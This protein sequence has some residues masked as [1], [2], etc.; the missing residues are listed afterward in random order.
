MPLL[1]HL[2]HALNIKL[3]ALLL[4]LLATMPSCTD[5]DE[6]LMEEMMPMIDSSS[7]V[8]FEPIGI[9]TLSLNSFIPVLPADIQV[10]FCRTIEQYYISSS[11]DPVTGEEQITNS[12][13]SYNA[14]NASGQMTIATD[15]N[16]RDSL[17]YDGEYIV[18]VIRNPGNDNF[19]QGESKAFYNYNAMELIS[20][21]TYEN[22]YSTQP[23][24]DT[25]Y[26][27][28]QEQIVRINTFVTNED[29]D[30]RWIATENLYTYY[31]DGLLRSYK[32]VSYE[33]TDICPNHPSTTLYFFWNHTDIKFP[34]APALYHI[35]KLSFDNIV[36]GQW[37]Y[38]YTSRQSYRNEGR[39]VPEASL[40]YNEYGYYNSRYS[41]LECL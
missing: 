14:Y 27:N 18:E 29:F 32:E 7:I 10:G 4:I 12:D 26:Y 41:K 21:I 15:W 11:I 36:L 20:T 39:D 6:T 2:H 9:D 16:F 22:W 37:T 34:D 35:S 30:E 23:R 31:P 8:G 28:E 17:I 25:F 40:T 1:R 13:T 24:I 5:E 33:C 19:G 3:I 38:A